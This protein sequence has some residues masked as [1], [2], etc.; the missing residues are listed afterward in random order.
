M[1]PLTLDAWDARQARELSENWY[2]DAEDALSDLQDCITILTKLEL[3][4]LLPAVYYHAL[5]LIGLDDG[6][7]QPIISFSTASLSYIFS[8][9]QMSRLTDGA[10]NVFRWSSY[11]VGGM[12]YL[13]FSLCTGARCEPTRRAML[14]DA[15]RRHILDPLALG[16][17]DELWT[18]DLC[19][20]CIIVL[21]AAWEEQRKKVWAV[22]PHAF[23]IHTGQEDRARWLAT[24]G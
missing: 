4:W 20:P 3:S 17:T 2:V 16:L 14:Q 8:E 23:G 10:M 5:V 22:L 13:N 6:D 9:P 12:H 19:S 7:H 18:T 21:R 24:L 15:E 11:I 1:C